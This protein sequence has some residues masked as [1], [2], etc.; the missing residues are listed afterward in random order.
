MK[1]KPLNQP[2]FSAVSVLKKSIVPL[3][4]LLT[5]GFSTVMASGV[6]PAIVSINIASANPT[7]A[8]SV[9]FTV[10]FSTDVHG[11]DASDFTVV[12]SGTN[13]SV[14]QVTGTGSSYTVTINGVSG[15]GNLGLNLNASGTGI[16]SDDTNDPIA[17]TGFTGQSYTIDTTP[18]TLTS[19]SYFSNNGYSSQYAKVNDNITLTVGF[20]EVLQSCTMTINGNAVAT[21]PSNGNRN[22]T[23]VYTATGTDNEG[24]VPWTIQAT[25]LAGN[26]RN[27]TNNDFGTFLAF[28]RTNPVVNIG[29]PVHAGV[30]D[31]TDQVDYAL[32]YTDANFNFSTLST[33]DITLD[34]TGT[35]DGT[36]QLN[37]S[38]TAYT[39][40]VTGITGS[41]TLGFSVAAN[42]AQDI[43]GNLADAGGPSAK[44][45]VG[46]LS[47]LTTTANLFGPTFDP[48]TT[49]GYTASVGELITSTTVTPTA[50]D[51]GTTLQVR[52]NGGT[53]AAVTSGA[54]SAPLPL[55]AGP[56]TI[57]VEAT[58]PDAVTK[59]V[60]TL[61]VNRAYSSDATL[62]TIAA[63]PNTKLTLVSGSNFRD[64]VASVKYNATTLAITATTREPM[65]TITV[66]GVAVASGAL[67]DP[68]TLNADT[69][70]IYTTITAGDGT[71]KKT[72][73]VLVTRQL[74][75]IATLATINLT[76]SAKLIRT[77]GTNYADYTATVETATS[78]LHVTATA[79]DP[80]A[81][82]T[83]N[84]VPTMSGVQSDVIMLNADT[85]TIYTT[86][87]AANV[88]IIKT[89]AILVTRKLSN[90]ANLATIKTTPSSKLTLVA[91]TNFHDY[92]ATAK[93]TT[94][95][96]SVT[97]TTREPSATVTV[98][99]VPVASGALSAPVTLNADTTTIYTTSTAANGVTKKT[100]A[101]LIT[102]L[103]SDVATL[104]TISTTPS[105]PLERSSGSNYVDYTTTVENATT[106]LSITANAQQSAAKI[107]VNGTPVNSGVLSAPVTLNTDT[108][109]IFTTITAEDGT[110]QK[111]YAILVTREPSSSRFAANFAR[112]GAVNDIIVHQNVSPNG[113]GQGDA[114]QIEGI[115]AYPD[116]KLQ[117]MNRSGNLVYEAKG[118][119]NTTKAFSGRANNGKLQQAGTYF[120]S[121]EYKVGKETKRQTGYIVLKY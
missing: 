93:S 4:L 106:E 60:Y 19:G 38:G 43:P 109:T 94:T 18:A 75:T 37:G 112:R 64:Y 26:V 2:A 29:A 54:A 71:T 16:L 67:S 49:G 3:M 98:N 115:T 105:S 118:Y 22:S 66:N 111:T 89:Y 1:S 50:A 85:T 28:D 9:D 35:A 21:T 58:A 104:A 7:N 56:N 114:M 59:E 47:N 10:T 5:L 13:G 65:A 97:V 102:R 11:V 23:A 83:I 8:A 76:P 107:T 62:T 117:I 90:V 78:A 74:S 113:D 41:G 53:Y 86:V 95:A 84:G 99:G 42:T 116:N 30:A 120:Y 108:T 82:I 92:T 39:V 14:L 17:E 51:A 27:Y 52:V 101:I 81:T 79:Q 57:E 24:N 77:T 68:I 48:L 45:F 31:L 88:R 32:N 46:A 100:Y 121:L 103:P 36:I 69:T 63:T 20:N 40:S 119:D 70:T 80:G 44:I 12:K 72:Y 87:T 25:D 15:N 96:V 73:A 55:I 110:T 34:K 33:G 61:T 6:T 91:G